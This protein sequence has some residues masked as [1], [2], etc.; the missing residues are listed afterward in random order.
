MK[1]RTL[2][3]G[4]ALLLR[5]LTAGACGGGVVVPSDLATGAQV[6]RILL[7]VH[8]TV[9]EVVT[10]IA[11]PEGA[12]DYGALI[13]VPVQ[14]TLDPDPVA[15][16]DLAALDDATRPTVYDS[17]DE[18]GGC[19]CIPTTGGDTGPEVPGIQLSEPVAIG[20]FSA[21]V[22]TAENGTALQAWLDEQGFVIPDASLPIVDSYAGS[23]KYFIALRSTAGRT[24]GPSSIG[25]HFTLPGDQRALPLRFV[26]ISAAPSVAFTIFVMAPNTIAPSAPFAALTLGDLP[27]NLLRQGQYAAAV[28]RAVNEHDGRAFVL[29]RGSEVKYL[30]LPAKL[31]PWIDPDALVTRL[32]TVMK[33]SAM[34][35]DVTFDTPYDQSIYGQ[36]YV[37]RETSPGPRPASAGTL[38][39]VVLAAALRRG[40][41]R[42]R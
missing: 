21:V 10:Q 1:A 35:V 16:E 12:G 8:G 3:L 33:P 24:P 25:L 26:S 34:T 20:P 13:P 19:I 37:R 7:S 39:L 29:E 31:R 36:T 38:L 15:E 9:T 14:P 23:G 2:A 27:D 32:S 41:R 6:Q 42:G 28:E 40:A 30:T 5:P 4:L 18:S 11:L 22:L 17:G